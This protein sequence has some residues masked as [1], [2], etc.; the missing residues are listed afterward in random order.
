MTLRSGKH[1][2]DVTIASGAGIA[3]VSR[4]ENEPN[5]PSISGSGSDIGLVDSKIDVGVLQSGA[6]P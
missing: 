4:N 1:R 6:A 2:F 3:T 5:V